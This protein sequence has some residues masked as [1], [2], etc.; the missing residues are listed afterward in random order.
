MTRCCA[1]SLVCARGRQHS[2]GQVRFLVQSCNHSSMPLFVAD[3]LFSL[4]LPAGSDPTGIPSRCASALK[5]YGRN[6]S[7]AV[8]EDNVRTLDFD[9]WWVGK[10]G[11]V[12]DSAMH[13]AWQGSEFGLAYR[14]GKAHLLKLN[15][16]IPAVAKVR[17]AEGKLQQR[18]EE[19]SVV[20]GEDVR[21]TI[22][23]S[24][25][26]QVLFP[27]SFCLVLKYLRLD[28]DDFE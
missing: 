8:A 13:T 1:A 16:L 27:Q 18:K 23:L 14:A 12:T 3:G 28:P 9:K 25:L 15:V 7:G 11:R 26:N 2:R 22:T 10:T 20:V 19:L 17:V 4:A 24:N 5:F 21:L 6:I